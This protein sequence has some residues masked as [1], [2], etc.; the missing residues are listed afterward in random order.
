M[1][2]KCIY[3]YK[4]EFNKNIE[5][6]FCNTSPMY[7]AGCIYTYT[8]YTAIY[9]YV[10]FVSQ[11]SELHPVTLPSFPPTGPQLP[12]KNIWGS[13]AGQIGSPSNTWGPESAVHFWK[14]IPFFQGPFSG[15]M[16]V[17]SDITI[18][19]NTFINGKLVHF[20]CLIKWNT[21]SKTFT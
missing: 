6:W 7:F 13:R 19:R 16:L 1:E 14:G 10:V 15:A 12:P 3:P 2:L 4:S 11:T 20:S 17:F 21:F 18:P 8:V 5:W 9:T